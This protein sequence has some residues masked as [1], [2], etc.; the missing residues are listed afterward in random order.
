MSVNL[1]LKFLTLYFTCIQSNKY[2]L[3]LNRVQKKF[4]LNITQIAAFIFEL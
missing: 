1:N 2:I 3:N 4:E